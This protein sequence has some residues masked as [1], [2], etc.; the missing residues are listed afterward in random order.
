MAKGWLSPFIR[1]PGGLLALLALIAPVS[2]RRRA[3][4]TPWWEVRCAL[5]VR[6]DYS[7]TDLGTTFSGEFLFKAR[8]EGAM[9]QDGPDF[10]LFHAKAEVLAWDLREKSAP[11][12]GAAVLT[13]R[14]A[15]TKPALRM[16]YV[17][18]EGPDILFSL[19]V[20]DLLI[21]LATSPEK[22]ALVLPRSKAPGADTAG[23]GD[24]ITKGTNVVVMG[25]EG[26]GEKSLERSFAWDWKRREWT[27]RERGSV[28]FAETHKVS[29]IISLVR[30]D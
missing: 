20:E 23:Y 21:P 26:L 12:T 17:V 16:N 11:P 1:I 15:P 25:E 28:K 24:F 5:T 3:Q 4:V 22:F 14:E 27:V 7:V 13:E 9:E 30:H 8:W 18:R 29:V 6:G 2:P 10:R 19:A